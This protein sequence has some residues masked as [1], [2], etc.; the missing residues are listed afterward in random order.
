MADDRFARARGNA[1][2][3][4][5]PSGSRGTY[6]L[7][8]YRVV[9]EIGVGGMASVHLARVDG[10]AG[11]QKWVAIKRIHPHLVEDPSF[12]N[13][14]LDEAK[15]AARISHPNVATVFKLEQHDDTYWIAMEYLH[16]EPLREVMRRTEEVGRIAPVEIACRIISDAAEGLH[17]AHELRGENG[18]FLGVVHRD[19]TPHNLFVTY[20]GTTKVVDFGI[21]KFSSRLAQT[22][23]G[24]VKGKLAYMSPEQV[25][26]EAVDR[27]TDIFALGVV[28]W[29]LTT[30]QRLFRMDSDIDTLA[31]VQECIVTPPSAI[32]R[33]YPRDLEAIVLKALAKDA[34]H[35]FQTAREFSRALQAYVLK[36][37]VFI[38]SDEVAAYMRAIFS[39]RIK[40]RDVYLRW[41]AEVTSTIDIDPKASPNESVVFPAEAAR[42]RGDITKAPPPPP[43]R[44][45]GRHP[46]PPPPR[47][48]VGALPAA[49]PALG[50]GG[51]K[52]DLVD[53]VRPGLKSPIVSPRVGLLGS[54]RVPSFAPDDGG[55]R[56]SG[57][58]ISGE[59]L[60][61]DLEDDEEDENNDTIVTNATFDELQ[62]LAAQGETSG[63]SIALELESDPRT[64]AAPPRPLTPPP[65]PAAAPPPRA[66]EGGAGPLTQRRAAQPSSIATDETLPPSEALLALPNLADLE[67]ASRSHAVHVERKRPSN[68]ALAVGGGLLGLA[69]VALVFFVFF[70]AN[71]TQTM[72]ATPV[73]SEPAAA[74]APRAE[75]APA[76]APTAAAPQAPPAPAPRE[77]KPAPPIRLE[78]ATV[79]G[80]PR[81]KP[82]Q[83]APTP[84]GSAGAAAQNAPTPVQSAATK[85]IGEATPA[86]GE[87]TVICMPACDDIRLD[88]VRIGESPII[89]RRVVVGEHHLEL[90]R[91]AQRETIVRRRTVHV[92][93]NHV[94]QVR[95][96]MTP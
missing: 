3:G 29:E 47:S 44:G 1:R 51:K 90:Q 84:V 81:P 30:G 7:G 66:P 36:R 35:R 24:M 16:G 18:D 15:V 25:S 55:D 96:S 76:P 49:A 39:D 26:G 69:F 86:F 34:N 32:V 61:G 91:L 68:L 72:T 59:T 54:A 83:G 21:A 9:D 56:P 74:P 31:K 17:A 63:V 58:G 70:P 22:R 87:L 5:K 11:F 89:R 41:A 12:V 6:F 88:G 19:V 45:G 23:A 33:D 82:A 67:G 77:A 60:V 95:E 71:R 94:E 20:E 40:N 42:G 57:S 14:F 62:R 13:M 92:T 79:N 37:G 43:P 48:T 93:E 46:T 4:Q 53:T 50:P 38:A 85:R 10:P 28:L 27:R 8:E 52:A 2:E 65:P 64:A 78:G 80:A 75:P 73:A